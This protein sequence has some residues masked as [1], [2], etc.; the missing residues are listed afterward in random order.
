VAY[1]LVINA[2]SSSIKAQLFDMSSHTSLYHTTLKE[3]VDYDLSLTHLFD[4]L[5]QNTSINSIDEIALFAHR[6]VHGGERY[7]Q[8]VVIDDEVID[9]IRSLSTLA[10]LHNPVNLKAI[11]AIAS[12][13]PSANQVAV[14]DTAFHQTIPPQAYTYALPLELQEKHH[15]RRYG[16]HGSS[17]KYLTHRAA[18]ALGK[19]GEEVNLIT[20]H[21]GNGA[22]ITA[23]KEGK[24]IDTSMGFTPLE[25]LVMGT[26]SGDIDSAI[27]FWLHNNLDMSYED[28]KKM[29]NK[30]SGLLGL[31]GISNMVE[32]ERLY[33]ENDKLAKQAIEIFAYRVKKYIG[34]YRAVLDDKVD[35]IIF[36]GGIGE[37]SALIRGL[38]MKNLDKTKNSSVTSECE[39]ISSDD[40][41]TPV[42]VI[43]TNE[44]LQIAKEAYALR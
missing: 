6:V 30:Q 43:K 4:D 32:L 18:D 21:L 22:S 9:D 3:V 36:S 37:N 16:F 10:P 13:L 17:H 2:G 15:V 40:A 8:A 27:I 39:V 25:G 26:R 11:E 31:T 28:I 1:T 20:V 42:M 41:T 44:E 38:I 23:I 29:L 24:S 34:A 12:K 5:I 33:Q 35:A 14:F 7:H 19:R